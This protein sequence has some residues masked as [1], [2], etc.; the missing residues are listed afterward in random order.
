MRQPMKTKPSPPKPKLPT[1]GKPL[2]IK[3]GSITVKVYAGTNRVNGL[4]YPQFT[5]VY[6]DHGKRVRK[7]FVG[8]S[9]A[10]QEAERVADLKS[11]DEGRVLAMR[12]EDMHVLLR[13]RDALKLLNRDRETPLEADFVCR[14]YAEAL[15]RLPTGKS[16]L[17]A[18]D[19]YAK[20]HVGHQTRTVEQVVQEFTEQK[21]KAKLS[22]VHLK[23]LE[24]RLSRFAEAVKVNIQA[25]DTAFLQAWL[26]GMKAEGRTKRNYLHHVRA[27]FRFA[28][29]RRYLAPEAMEE[30][31]AVQREKE[32][33]ED[34]H[35]FTPTE[36]REILGAA[37][38]EMIPFLALGAFAGIRSAELA[39][40]DW[41]D[42][43]LA[44]GHVE[45]AKEKAKTRARRLVPI[46]ENL[47]AW[48]TPHA[49]RFGP[50]VP[51]DSWW[52]Q[53]TR[54]TEDVN[55]IRREK[56]EAAGVKPEPF[57]WHQNALRHSFCSYRLAVV[58][59]ADQVALEAGNSPQKIFSNYRKLVTDAEAER[60]FSIEPDRARDV[61]PMP[62]AIDQVAEG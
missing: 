44:E 22:D 50:V 59:S 60:W 41:R 52:N 54:L 42:V 9:E 48:L 8:C 26:D 3:R 39:R 15:K 1:P 62:A 49:Q 23:D 35:V 33:T 25:V 10:I 57:T 5:V 27:L 30:I 45:V 6:F 7:R 14:E 13:A 34:V 61:V 20:R 17:E 31:V 46:S 21:R 47:A 19:F 24:S 2:V 55:R 40:L 37:K 38:P 43:D 29:R 56:A 11:R 28:I 4:E 51:F 53:L 58:K 32:K 18:V 36:M 16:L 12:S